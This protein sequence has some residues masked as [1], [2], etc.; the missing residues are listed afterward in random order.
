ME[1]PRHGGRFF[2]NRRTF[3]G[4]SAAG[5][6]AAPILQSSVWAA[7]PQRLRVGLIGCGGRGTGAAFN[8]AQ[9]SPDVEIA[10]LG[11]VFPDRLAGCREH[12]KQLGDRVTVTDDDCATG[13]DAFKTVCGRPDIDLVI[14]ATPPHFRPMMFAEAIERGKHVFM[15][16]PVAVDPAGVRLV[17]KAG[18]LADQKSLSVVSG[19]QRRH[20]ACYLEAMQRIRDGEI[21][22]PVA[23]RCYWN[24][25]GL[26]NRGRQD[27]WSDMEWQLRNWLYFTWLSGDH[28]VEQHVHN[29]DAVNWAFGGHP[30]R[31]TG[32]GGRQSRVQPEYGHCFD[33]FAVDFE[34]PDGAHALS[35][36]RQADGS[37]GRV[38]E[39]VQG[40]RG[41]SLTSSGRARF[42][43]GSGWQFE[44]DNPNPYVQEHRDLQNSIRGEGPRLNEARRI[45][46]STLTAIMGRMSA[47]SGKELT[48]DEALNAPLDLS[49]PTYAFADLEVPAVAIPGR[50]HPH[51]SLWTPEV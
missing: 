28:I 29:I 15:E 48:W 32:M 16:K 41:R 6:A 33:H 42:E 49:P 23:A 45:A 19:T 3:I 14:L 4:T 38:E 26:W 1:Q 31:C 27:D 20:E 10:A 22:E 8:A 13:W 25:G 18:E 35:M 7:G 5:L 11:D 39:V 51:D 34:Y 24:Q 2:V 44:G 36:C 21:G 40:T 9:A 12:L 43:G 50:T 17:M 37:G 47:Y 46:E 30:I